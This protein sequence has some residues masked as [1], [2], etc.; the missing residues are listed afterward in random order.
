[1]GLLGAIKS[2]F[3]TKRVNLENR[4]NFSKKWIQGASGRF[5]IVQDKS[6]GKKYGLKILDPNKTKQFRDKFPGKGFESESQIAFSLKHPSIVRTI[7][8]GQTTNGNEFLLMEYIDGPHLET[9]FQE[10][11]ETVREKALTIIKQ[12]AGAIQ[13]I[14]EARYIHRD[15]CPRNILLS[16]TG[17]QAKL[18]DFSLT[19]PNAPE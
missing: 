14:H 13:S 2:A 9:V 12:L 5:H 16:K 6:D 10:R 17:D 3:G 19:V 7:E 8:I 11:N 1:M 18:F 15:I 4:F